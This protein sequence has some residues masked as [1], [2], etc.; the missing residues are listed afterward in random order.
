MSSF[1]ELALVYDATV[2]WNSR[3]SRELPFLLKLMEEK[4][5]G[6][7]LDLAC[8]SG[9]HAIALAK[10]GFLVMGIDKSVEMIKAAI[11]YSEIANVN[12]HFLVAD[13]VDVDRVVEGPFDLILCLG[14]SLALLPRLKELRRLVASIYS[15]LGKNGV[16]LAQILNFTEIRKTGFQFFPIREGR[17]SSGVKVIFSR[18]FAPI[19]NTETVSLIL[20]AFMKQPEGWMAEMA[21]QQVLQLNDAILDE[22]IRKSGYSEWEFYSDYEQ[23]PFQS[24]SHRNLILL[25]RR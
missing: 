4:G 25:A 24:E 23:N 11:K 7:I 22:T 18:F 21:A 5:K 19:D 17:L 1:D 14:N 10:K 6:R 16:F 8:G 20:S 12:V 9:R 13:M 15:L 3:I 2:E